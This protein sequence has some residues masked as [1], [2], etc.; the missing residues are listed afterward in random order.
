MPYWLATV[1][2]CAF[3]A[4]ARAFASGK[5]LIPGG[6]F[7]R[8][9]GQRRLIR[10]HRVA[11]GIRGRIGA[12]IEQRVPTHHEQNQRHNDYSDGDCLLCVVL[13][14]VHSMFGQGDELVLFLQLPF[15][16][17][18][19]VVRCSRLEESLIAP[20]HRGRTLKCISQPFHGPETALKDRSYPASAMP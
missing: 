5:V 8:L 6:R 14:P 19:H 10:L 1:R 20:A 12:V 7:G 3:A 4:V 15:G 2:N 13:R 16:C 18:V 9:G 11:E 17:V